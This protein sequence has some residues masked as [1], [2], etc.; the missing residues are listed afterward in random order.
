MSILKVGVTGANG[1]VGRRLYE[2]M[3][4]LPDFEPVAFVRSDDRLASQKDSPPRFIGS[5]DNPVNLAQATEGLDVLVHC[6]ARVHVMEDTSED[7]LEEYRKTNVIGTMKL[8][9]QCAASGVKRFVYISSIKVNGEETEAGEVYRSIDQPM[10]EDPYGISKCEAERALRDFSEQSCMELVI[11]RPPLVYGPGVKGNFA[12]LLSLIGKGIPLPLGA[13]NNA[14]S[15]VALDNLIDLIVCCASHPKAAGQVFLVSDGKP[16]STTE[17]LRGIATAMDKRCWLIPVPE[18]IFRA[19]LGLLG[20]KAIA[21]R[22]FG[23]LVVDITHTKE[24]LGWEPSISLEE[25]LRRAIGS[26]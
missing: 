23:S 24:T 25:G 12:S 4:D 7:P 16:I 8:A 5:L 20:K 6:A 2:C 1:F 19:G 14:R 3:V 11:I 26:S 21:D 15:L 13:V 22:L 17:L 10:P 9:E 18:W